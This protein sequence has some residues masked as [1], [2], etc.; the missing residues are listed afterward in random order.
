MA[1]AEGNELRR[2]LGDYTIPST[3]SYGS[4]IAQP[5]VE[6]NNRARI[7]KT[8]V[9]SRIALCGPTSLLIWVLALY[10]YRESIGWRFSLHIFQAFQN[11][12]L[13]SKRTI[14]PQRL[15]KALSSSFLVSLMEE[16]AMLQCMV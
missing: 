10:A 5:N 16:T 8:R 4:S 7:G 12:V 1:A 2:T 13:C 6:A 15:L 9:S 11:C 14:F 3:T